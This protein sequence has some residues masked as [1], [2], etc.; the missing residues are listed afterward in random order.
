[1]R[2][3][4]DRADLKAGRPIG[5]F[6]AAH[7]Y[8]ARDVRGAPSASVI[9]SGKIISLRDDVGQTERNVEVQNIG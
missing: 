6:R 5:A 8:F 2:P 7:T 9:G 4:A 3:V 1:V